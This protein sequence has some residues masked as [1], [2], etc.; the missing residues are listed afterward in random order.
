MDFSWADTFDVAE[1]KV[2]PWNRYGQRRLY[3]NT[4]SGDRVGWFDQNRKLAVLER[5][6]LRQEFQRALGANGIDPRSISVA[7]GVRGATGADSGE[8]NSTSPV[9]EVPEFSEM[10]YSPTDSSA[11]DGHTDLVSIPPRAAEVGS[12]W[13]DLTLNLPG[14]SVSEQATALR[15]AAP[16]RTLVARAAGVH[17]NERAF[18]VGARGEVKVAHRLA[19]LPDGWKVLHSV[20]IG[21]RGSDI[22]HVIIGPSGLFTVNTKHHPDSNVW[23]RGDTFK[24]NGKNQPYVPKARFEA[25]RASRM[26]SVASNVPVS[27]RGVIAVVGARGGFTVK[28]QPPDGIVHVIGRKKLVPWLLSHGSIYSKEEVAAI[29]DRARRSTTWM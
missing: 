9:L 6:D 17:S 29:F 18:R 19:G 12:P 2:V 27:V 5:E 11:P 1:L 16:I 28:A 20:P 21:S 10:G 24:V 26:L 3:V 22:D 13:I 8:G 15:R 7:N 23:V 14:Q 25:Q 4:V